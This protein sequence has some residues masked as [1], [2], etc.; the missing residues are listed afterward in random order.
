MQLRSAVAERP[1]IGTFVAINN[2]TV[3]EI[4]GRSGFE[5]LC[6][7][8][9]HASFGPVDVEGLI[10]AADAVGATTIVRVSSIG[11]EIARA[12]D[13][14]AAGVLVPMVETVAQAEQV[15]QAV[16]YPPIGT[17]GAGIG[18][19]AAYGM[20]FGEYFGSA[21]DR[22]VA[23][24]QIETARAVENVD[25]ILAVPGIDVAFV[26][27]GDL[28][29]SLGAPMGTPEH[30]AAVDRVISAAQ[31]A[32][33]PVGMFCLD[34]ASAKAWAEKG[35]TFFLLSVDLAMLSGRAGE[36]VRSAR[37]AFGAEVPA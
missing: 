29:V 13:S 24:V 22:V 32:G 34:A 10:R 28:A 6:L 9:E 33:V 15:A 16:R 25:A 2:P 21:N 11:A 4:L 12:L 1:V 35:V 20:R 14:G 30:T 31:R 18:R 36:L 23:M 26:G 3:V 8:T 5:V 17:R 7:D 37:A 19:A 27:P